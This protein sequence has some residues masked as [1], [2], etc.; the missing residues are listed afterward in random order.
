MR[1]IVAD[2]SLGTVLTVFS[3]PQIIVLPQKNRSNGFFG[4]SERLVHRDKATV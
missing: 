3:S 2:K 1:D 4:L